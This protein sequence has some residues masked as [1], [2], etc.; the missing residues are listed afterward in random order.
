MYFLVYDQ[1]SSLDT[2]TYIHVVVVAAAARML[3]IL[4]QLA[5]NIN[6]TGKIFNKCYDKTWNYLVLSGLYVS[7]NDFVLNG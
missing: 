4:G 5:S 2:H 7:M 6:T 1:M 3:L